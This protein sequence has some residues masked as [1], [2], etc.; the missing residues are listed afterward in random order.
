MSKQ[1]LGIDHQKNLV[2]AAN[3][4]YGGENSLFE[5]YLVVSS[6]LSIMDVQYN[7]SNSNLRISKTS[8]IRTKF[9]SPTAIFSLY[10]TPP[11]SNI[12]VIR[13]ISVVP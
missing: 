5:V 3:V 1:Y 9:Y 11:N 8:L 10:L 6:Y 13:T 4:T 7:L 2:P 12:S